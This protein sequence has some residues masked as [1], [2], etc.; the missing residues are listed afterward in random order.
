LFNNS[1]LEFTV[2]I[3]FLI[4][5]IIIAYIDLKTHYIYDITSNLLL[6]Y[7]VIVFVVKFIICMPYLCTL[8]GIV[9]GYFIIFIFSKLK[10]IGQGDLKI[11]L[12]SFLLIDKSFLCP[13][14]LIIFSLGI[15]GFF[16]IIELI[17]RKITIES[18]RALCPAIAIAVFIMMILT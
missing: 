17:S 4:I 12:A 14:I 9:F 13:I 16:G 11:Y 1:I 7:S 8:I 3:V 10:F 5:L 2:E 15:S 18:R 6:G